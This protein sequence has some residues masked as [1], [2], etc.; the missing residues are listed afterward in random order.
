MHGT[1]IA[2]LPILPLVVG[3]LIMST[4]AAAEIRF[5][6]VSAKAGMVHTGASQG[7]SW[8]DFNGDGWP[9]LWVGNHYEPPSLYVNQQDGTF[10]NVI[11]SVWSGDPQADKH[12]AAWADFDND[13]DQDLLVLVGAVMGRGR[14]GNLLFVNQNGMLRDEAQ[15]WGLDYPFGRGRTP[16]WFDADHDGRLD[17]VLMTAPRPDGKAPSAVFRQTPNGFVLY[18]LQARFQHAQPSRLQSIGYLLH[19]LVHLDFSL[20]TWIQA[21]EFAQ[22]ADLSGNGLLD[23]VAFTNPVRLYSLKAVPFDDFTH[24]IGFPGDP[25]ASRQANWLSFLRISNLLSGVSDAVIEDFDGD[26]QVDI[27]LARPRRPDSEVIQP[28]PFEISGTF[29]GSSRKGD[30][31]TLHFRTSSNVTFQLN[32]PWEG[33]SNPFATPLEVII[34]ASRKHTATEPFTLTPDDPSVRGSVP[35]QAAMD[36]GEVSIVYDP[37]SSVWTLSSSGRRINFIL[38]SAE[39]M[40]QVR[41]AGLK[42]FDNQGA[43]LL[44]VRR[45]EHFVT[46]TLP[47]PIDQAA[48]H[49]VVAGDFDNDM[50]LDI[51]L[52]CTGQAGNLA[53]RL[54]ENDSNGN[55]REVPGAGGAAGS[56]LGRGDAV[57]IADYDRD[58]FLDLFVTNGFGPRPFADEGPHQLFHNMGNGNHWL[59]I[60]LEGTVSNR[61]GIGAR[62]VLEAG[63]VVQIRGQG[64]G[65]HRDSQN[66]QRIHFGLAQHTVADR[67]TVRWPSGIQQQLEKIQADQMLRIK[68]QP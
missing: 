25:I 11:A 21:A 55:F 65:M 14:G 66:H 62:V 59:E 6:E 58:G 41:S 43:D 15:R 16:L 61:D 34:G 20:P 38:R 18:S 19:N 36:S 5:E 28:T 64:G 3:L 9:D 32:V 47:R 31:K 51:Y 52:V 7:A 37:A 68:E 27:Y 44:L 56:K 57:A 4:V 50:D 54:L 42:P 26:G 24:R 17:V 2:R 22:L 45:G 40:E 10:V 63:G 39:A 1:I 48:C 67:L 35:A 60:D 29:A 49:S 30:A 23:L 46:K 53:N 13:G 12:G 33:P 8:G